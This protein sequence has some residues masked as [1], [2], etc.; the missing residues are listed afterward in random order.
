MV[1][2]EREELT[3]ILIGT[4]CTRTEFILVRRLG[5]SMAGLDLTITL[6]YELSSKPS[7]TVYTHFF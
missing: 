1:T 3:P 6:V 2:P 5:I 4:V 7:Y